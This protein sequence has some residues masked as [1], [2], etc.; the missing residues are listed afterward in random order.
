MNREFA[1]GMEDKGYE[2]LKQFNKFLHIQQLVRTPRNYQACDASGYTT[3]GTPIVIEIKV[4][5]QKYDG[6]KVIGKNYTADTIYIEDHKVGS[7]LLEH[8]V[9]KSIPLYVNFLD[10]AIIVYNLAKLS[11][12]PNITSQK[13]KSK[14]YEG[15]EICKRVELPLDEAYVYNNNFELIQKPNDQQR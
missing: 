6:D 2:L 5:N 9:N 11:K 1:Y 15:I 7:M 8:V 12:R 10:D 14:L 13:I 4:R 3:D